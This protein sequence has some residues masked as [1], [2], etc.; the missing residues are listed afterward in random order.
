VPPSLECRADELGVRER[1]VPIVRH[2]AVAVQSSSSE[3]PQCGSLNFSAAVCARSAWR[4]TMPITSTRLS[5]FS[6]G[7]WRE[8]VTQPAPI[9]TTFSVIEPCRRHPSSQS[10]RYRTLGR[11][12]LSGRR[13]AMA[14]EE[15]RV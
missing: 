15:W 11:G 9:E 6:A 2:C 3:V 1:G 7:R 4:S 12:L 14:K 5:R 10:R 8:V 13:D